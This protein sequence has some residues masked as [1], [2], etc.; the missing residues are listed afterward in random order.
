ML[1]VDDHALFA[2]ALA[3]RLS[4]EP[5]LVVLPIAGD[6]R[7]AR[8]LV[9]TER[10]HIVLLD[11]MLGRE[12]GLDVLD[13]LRTAAPDVRGVVLSALTEID[14]VVRAVRYGAVGWVSKAEGAD[15][16]ARV[17]RDAARQGGRLPPEILGEVLR[18]L[19]ARTPEQ[20]T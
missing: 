3:T 15:L 18:R 4:R 5:D 1:I 11:M 19:L 9:D 6:V 7:R 12:T 16:V 10:P 8:A 13:H 20:P 14:A 17:V 2:E